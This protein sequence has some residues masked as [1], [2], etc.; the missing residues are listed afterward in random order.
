MKTYSDVLRNP[1]RYYPKLHLKN[2]FKVSETSVVMGIS[3]KQ[4]YQNV[5]KNKSLTFKN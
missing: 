5:H 1:E 3:K 4:L 2:D